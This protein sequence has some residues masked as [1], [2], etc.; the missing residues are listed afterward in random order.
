MTHGPKPVTVLPGLTLTSALMVPPVTH[1][2]AV[3]AMMPL[4]EAAPRST[5]AVG[6]VVALSERLGKRL[7]QL[8][9][10]DFQGIDKHFKSDALKVLDL[11][12]ALVRRELIGAPGPREIKKQLAR[13]RKRVEGKRK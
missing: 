3:P 10:D 1:V 4:G 9:L 13:W 8:T 11:K 6:G 5:N 12:Q 7:D 2:T